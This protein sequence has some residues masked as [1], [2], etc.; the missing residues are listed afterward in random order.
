VSVSTHGTAAVKYP[1]KER[2]A[3]LTSKLTI[4][5]T[6]AGETISI[7]WRT[8][9]IKLWNREEASNFTESDVTGKYQNWVDKLHK[10]MGGIPFKLFV[11]KCATKTPKGVRTWILSLADGLI[12]RG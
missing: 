10:S 7:P 4:R 12:R 2:F 6:R 8:K 3:I 5:I 9:E 11:A 1:D